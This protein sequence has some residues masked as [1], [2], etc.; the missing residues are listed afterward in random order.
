MRGC[1]T[2]G[3]TLVGVI[4]QDRVRAPDATIRR[5]W[6]VTVVGAE[7][8]A[9]AGAGFGV[10]GGGEIAKVVGVEV[11]LACVEAGGGK[12][13]AGDDAVAVGAGVPAQTA[14]EGEDVVAEFGRQVQESDGWRVM[15]GWRCG[16]GR[17]G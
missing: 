2:G 14:A 5:S 12:P 16:T 10:V 11:L 7:V 6:H 9:E 3:G 8:S 17:K 13:L 15:R 1:G 4:Q